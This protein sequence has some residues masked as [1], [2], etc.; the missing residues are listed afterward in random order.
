MAAA[1]RGDFALETSAPKALFETHLFGGT[2]TI[3]G[4]RQQYDV[5]PDGQH[6]LINVRLAE[7]SSSPI[8]LV[9]NWTTAL[10]K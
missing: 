6:F 4:F 5:A 3:A 8:T 10:K 1:V 7:E 2:R 9:L